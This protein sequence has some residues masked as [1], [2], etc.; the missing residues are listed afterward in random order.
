MIVTFHS[1]KG[2]TGKTLLSVNLAI[3]FA[4]MGKRVCLLDL[5]LRAPSLHSTFKNGKKHWVNDFLNKACTIDNVLTDCSTEAMGKG[6][7]LVGLAN[8]STET[9]R[10]MAAKDRK[11][12]M[13]ALGRLLSLKMSLL[14]ICTSIMYSLIPARVFNLYKCHR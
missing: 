10:E 13:E 1:Y 7:L 12:E 5:D 3:I 11:W 14:T 9:I 6:K 2:G 4:K 8:P